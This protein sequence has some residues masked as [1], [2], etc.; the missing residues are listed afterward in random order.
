MPLQRAQELLSLRLLPI[1]LWAQDTLGTGYNYHRHM[2]ARTI[3]LVYDNL[4][5]AQVT[6]ES[7]LDGDE[8]H[9]HQLRLE[10]ELVRLEDGHRRYTCLYCLEPLSIRG[11]TDRVYHF[12]HPKNPGAE[13][14]YRSGFSLS[15]DEWEALRYNGSKESEA[16]R[17]VKAWVAESLRADRDVELGSVVED[18]RMQSWRDRS[19]W[20]KPDVRG[21]WK[22]KTLVFEAQLSTTFVATIAARRQF[23]LSEGALLFWIFR[24]FALSENEMR[25]SERDVFYNNNWNIFS[26]DA[27]S[28]QASRQ[29]TEL[30]L[31]CRWQQPVVDGMAIR[32]Q[33]HK[34]LV[35]FSELTLDF[36]RQRAFYFDFETALKEVQTTL[37]GAT[38]AAFHEARRER[39]FGLPEHGV[40]RQEIAGDAEL[41]KWLG[42]EARYDTMPS[43][44]ERAW[45][46]ADTS[47]RFSMRRVQDYAYSV[48]APYLRV[49]CQTAPKTLQG[50]EDLRTILS[51]LISLRLG[52]VVGSR[53]INLKHVEDS[54]FHSAFGYYGV[55]RYAAGVY[56]RQRDIGYDIP[57]SIATENA[58]IHVARKAENHDVVT[59]DFD[60]AFMIL[61]P[62]LKPAR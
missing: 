54:V 35:G 53:S 30:K 26:I 39:R 36:E 6:A 17:Q 62:E 25:F 50:R 46:A 38:A 27:E 41:A 14:P 45:L 44:I 20:R 24:D 12:A 4:N 9:K 43:E 7:V 52:R 58:R 33:W 59:R 1:L 34:K 31:W 11:S 51:A 47:D 29:S 49:A 16:H 22:G 10:D 40:L 60:R 5:Y 8:A 23:Y 56:G 3:D 57:N 2:A 48:L 37:M 19:K 15:Q 42:L 28:V 32:Y 61:F 21:T 13:C 18:S 55:F